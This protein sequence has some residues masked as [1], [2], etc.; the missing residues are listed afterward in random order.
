M[1]RNESI[2]V[3]AV[4]GLLFVILFVAVVFGD[5]GQPQPEQQ[6]VAKESQQKEEE[7]DQV[8][9]VDDPI[10][11]L[12]DH[13]NVD[14]GLGMREVGGTEERSAEVG[15][16]ETNEAPATVTEPVATPEAPIS[17]PKAATPPPIALDMGT[18]VGQ[19]R[20]VRVRPGDTFSLLVQRYTG[21]L[22]TM[23]TC[24]A[25][26][27]EVDKNNLRPGS[28][29]IMPWVDDAELTAKAAERQVA[30][31]KQEQERLSGKTYE[32]KAGD[33]LWKI[34]MKNTSDKGRAARIVSEIMGL[35]PGL[36][37]ERLKVGQKIL[38][39]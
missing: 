22:D 14:K 37:P 34:A 3:Y 18:R 1:Q 24:E 28:T 26:N 38:V 6:P 23:A 21:S 19:F 27:E 32:V 4:T 16:T 5:E 25:L 29:L 17:E 10:R 20:E 39:P 36:E 31:N 15:G 7:L 33:N 9:D 11:D 30:S 13:L 35:N 2:L 8:A 12:L